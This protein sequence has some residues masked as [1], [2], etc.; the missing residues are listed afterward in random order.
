VSKRR[1]RREKRKRGR[2]R[3]RRRR[4]GAFNITALPTRGFDSN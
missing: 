3:R 2:K 1:K 4:K